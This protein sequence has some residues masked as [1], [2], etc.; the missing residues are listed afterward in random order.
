MLTTQ[1]DR[2]VVE[3]FFTWSSKGWELLL[4]IGVFGCSLGMYVAVHEFVRSG[5][6]TIVVG[7]AVFAYGWRRKVRLRA[8][9]ATFKRARNDDF[10][11]VLL[12]SM[13][14]TDLDPR[15]FID[16]NMPEFVALDP[17]R[18]SEPER[19]QLEAIKP[20]ALF[21]VGREGDDDGSGQWRFMKGGEL[22]IFEHSPILVSILYLTRSELILYTANVD[23]TKGDLLQEQLHRVLLREITE[24]TASS[25]TNRLLRAAHASLF[26]KHEKTMKVTLEGD[27]IRLRNTLQV[28]KRNGQ[29]LKFWASAP[30]YRAGEQSVLDYDPYEGDSFRFVARRISQAIHSA[31]EP[32]AAPSAANAAAR[33]QRQA[34]DAT[35]GR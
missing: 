32:A 17:S 24:I 4:A 19:Q 10:I 33:P 34:A 12:R 27:L 29:A 9:Y 15:T 2:T 5:L 3:T 1:T 13:A 23:V 25:S 22:A 14:K 20:K 30:Q 6:V 21:L 28:S 18:V 31:N 16:L 7:L 11:R 8:L 26:T 35:R